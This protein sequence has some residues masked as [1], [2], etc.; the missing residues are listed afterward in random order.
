MANKR[1]TDTPAETPAP[2]PAP[3]VTF[4]I[5]EGDKKV[6]EQTLD[7]AFAPVLLAGQRAE[8]V[9]PKAAD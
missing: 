4:A 7:A 6:G 3:P 1:T 2:E 9:E 8:L 5:Y